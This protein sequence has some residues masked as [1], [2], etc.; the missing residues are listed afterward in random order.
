ML[1]SSK[2]LKWKRSIAIVNCGASS[3]VSSQRSDTLQ[4]TA[5]TTRGWG[6]KRDF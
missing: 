6:C 4:S 2:I 1:E 5:P 3:K